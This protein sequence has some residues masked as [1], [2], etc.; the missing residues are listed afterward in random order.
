LTYAAAGGVEHVRER[1]I[2]PMLEDG[3]T[4]AVTLTLTAATWLEAA[5]E[6]TKIE[7]LTGLP[8]AALLAYLTRVFPTQPST[9]TP[10]FR[11]P[12]TS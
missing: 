10:P 9:V 8:C 2:E 11:R 1:L 12:Q 6:L 4:V 7:S 5:G 3:W